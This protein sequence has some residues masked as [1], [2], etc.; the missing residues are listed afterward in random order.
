MLGESTRSNKAARYES[1]NQ[2]SARFGS[3]AARPCRKNGMSPAACEMMVPTAL[4]SLSHEKNL[5]A[6]TKTES[7]PLYVVYRLEEFT[8]DGEHRRA[9]NPR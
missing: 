9:C 3:S 1:L 8:K 4:D 2:A 7:K 6:F 5:A